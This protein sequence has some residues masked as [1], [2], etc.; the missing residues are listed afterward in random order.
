MRGKLLTYYLI[1]QYSCVDS[2]P[3][4]N[5]VMHPF[6]NAVVKVTKHHHWHAINFN[7]V[8]FFSLSHKLCPKWVAPNLL[9]LIG[10]SLILSNFLLLTYYDW[11]YSATSNEQGLTHSP[12]PQWVWLYCGISHFVGYTL[13]GIDG[14]QARRTE[15]STP[16]GKEKYYEITHLLL[17]YG[18]TKSMV[19]LYLPPSLPLCLP[20]PLPLSRQVNYLIMGWI[21]GVQYSYQCH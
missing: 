3:L 6:W 20:L 4:S 18:Y 10:W 2:S 11:D 8:I 17:W 21:V 1:M 19:S 12:I 7:Y 9:T 5:Y 16:L 13:D 15:S 14:K